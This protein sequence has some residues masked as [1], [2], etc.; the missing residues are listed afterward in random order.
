[1]PFG[2]GA[3]EPGE[4][5]RLAL[6]VL[7]EQRS[8]RRAPPGGCSTNG[9]RPLRRSFGQRL[10]DERRAPAQRELTVVVAIRRA[11]ARHVRPAASRSPPGRSARR[12]RAVPKRPR[13]SARSRRTG[14]PQ[15]PARGRRAGCRT[16]RA[17]P[18][19]WLS[20][21]AASSISDR[22]SPYGGVRRAAATTAPSVLD[23]GE[24]RRSLP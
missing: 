12:R 16:R 7:P 18:R 1:M 19:R 14:A 6:R 22:M 3:A 5:H 23:D 24:I 15:R 4:R 9:R 10:F 21:R 8:R 11:T 20:T 13:G 17:R 2:V